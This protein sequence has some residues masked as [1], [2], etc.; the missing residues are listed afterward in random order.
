MYFDSCCNYQG[1]HTLSPFFA[2]QIDNIPSRTG[3]EQADHPKKIKMAFVTPSP[4]WPLA[5]SR[6]QCDLHGS[7]R[8]S[9][10]QR[11][12]CLLDQWTLMETAKVISTTQG[13]VGDFNQ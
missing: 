5:A 3:L 7:F 13:L 9:L 6:S 12:L 10:A 2:P 11:E 8:P 1:Y 4:P